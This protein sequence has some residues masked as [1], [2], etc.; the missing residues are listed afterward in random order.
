MTLNQATSAV[1]WRAKPFHEDSFDSVVIV[2]LNEKL[3]AKASLALKIVNQ[4]SVQVLLLY[5]LLWTFFRKQ[6]W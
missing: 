6:N 4:T 5:E 1:I 3:V 2:A